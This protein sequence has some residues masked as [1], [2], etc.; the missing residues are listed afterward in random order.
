MNSV[1][2]ESFVLNNKETL[3]INGGNPVRSDPLPS[4][5]LGVNVMGDEE[6]K[7]LTEVIIKQSPFRAYGKNPPHMVDDFESLT[8]EYFKMPYSLATTSGTSALCCAMAGLEIG[9]GD[10]VIIP[11]L[12]W[13]SDFNAPVLFGAIPVFADINRSLNLDPED[14]ERKITKRTKAV[15]VIHFQGATTDMDKILD[16]AKKY[17]IKVLEDCAQACGTAYKNRKVGSL[18][19]V[20]IF[21]FQQNKVI[22]AGEGGLL[23]TKNAKI[24]ERSVRYHDLG[25]FRPAF[26]KQ[27]Q[28][29]H[30]QQFAG[31]QFRMSE[32]TGAVLIAQLKKLDS[33]ILDITRNYHKK[34]KKQLTTE[35]DGIKFRQTGDDEGEAGTALYID[36]DN[37]EKVEWVNKALLAE[38]IHS[39]PCSSCLNLLHVD[40]IQKKRQVHINMPPFGKGYLG[41]TVQY[42][43]ELCPNTD[44]IINSMVCVP[45][46]QNYSDNDVN[47]IA[48]AI[49]KIWNA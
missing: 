23:L 14:F 7:L 44:K 39:S 20:S 2:S 31:C 5:Y 13:Y 32:L 28:D 34:L 15:I 45:V 29:E 8:R 4:P 9:Y 6:L 48:R 17:N 46:S 47:D 41:E 38:G 22:S 49:I 12:G 40:Y 33:H 36:F 18:G 37:A 27:S 19:D 25:M 35:C 26:K 1:N 11:S 16:I 10:E 3:A 24:F 21:S 42:Y 30:F 43:P